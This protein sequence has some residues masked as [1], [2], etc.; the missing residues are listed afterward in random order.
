[1]HRSTSSGDLAPVKS[2]RKAFFPPSRVQLIPSYPVD[3]PTAKG[4]K[5]QSRREN[6]GPGD[7]NDG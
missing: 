5:P 6:D 4:S 2:F 3:Y 7:L 1:M